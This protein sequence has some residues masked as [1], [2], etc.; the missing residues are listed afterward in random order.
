MQNHR[1]EILLEK[2]KLPKVKKEQNRPQEVSHVGTQKSDSFAS[3]QL[4]SSYEPKDSLSNHS[5]ED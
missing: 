1:E 2:E 4:C 3:S 5:V